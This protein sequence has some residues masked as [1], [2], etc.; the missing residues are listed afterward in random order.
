MISLVPVPD[1]FVKWP[2]S[3]VYSGCDHALLGAWLGR[4]AH[5]RCEPIRQVYLRFAPMFEN[6]RKA[7]FSRY[8]RI[9]TMTMEHY[10]ATR[11]PSS[12]RRE[13]EAARKKHAHRIDNSFVLWQPP[14]TTTECF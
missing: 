3:I 6:V 5:L 12:K 13:L 14:E 7:L 2:T 1:E 11:E 10:I 8:G 4:F 9:P